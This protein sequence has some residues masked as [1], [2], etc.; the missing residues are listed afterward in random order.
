MCLGCLDD[1]E[2]PATR[3]E[4]LA[5]AL[6]LTAVSALGATAV[7]DAAARVWDIEARGLTVDNDGTLLPAYIA[8]PMGADNRTTVVILHDSPGIPKELQEMARDVARTGYVAL[9]I[10][11]AL[12]GTARISTHPDALLSET[13]SRDVQSDV[14]AGILTLNGNMPNANP[15]VIVGIGSAGYTALRLALNDPLSVVGVIVMDTPIEDAERSNTDPRPDLI[16]LLA[17]L[18]VPVQFHAGTADPAISREQL[19]WLSRFV[20]VDP[21]RRE[22]FLYGGAGPDFY[23][24]S[25]ANFDKGYHMLARKRWQEFLAERFS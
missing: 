17:R 10:D 19:N 2:P 16:T 18:N 8:N 13:F 15:A 14:R 25:S 24:S 12:R 1:D 21:E 9:V 22:L 6:Q 3:R 11:C 23:L 7:A 4:F 20:A 5:A